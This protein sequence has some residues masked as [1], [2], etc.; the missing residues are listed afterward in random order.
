MTRPG[1]QVA[2]KPTPKPSA[3]EMQ[4]AQELTALQHKLAASEECL[5]ME[6]SRLSELQKSFNAFKMYHG[7]V[8]VAMAAFAVY[9]SL[10]NQEIRDAVR[11]GYEKFTL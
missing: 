10:G 8:F 4:Y 3:E 6:R 9:A 11:L 5:R 7:C 2:K 1:C